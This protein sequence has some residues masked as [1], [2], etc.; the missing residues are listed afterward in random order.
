MQWSERIGRRVKLRDLHVLEAVV[1]AGSM[2]KAADK[3][4]ITVP[5]ISKAI[6]DLEHCV[7]VRLLDRSARGVEVT[8]SGRAL[9]SRSRAAFD[10]LRQGIRDIEQLSDPTAG[11]VRIG[12]TVPL[13]SSFVSAVID[14]FSKR[15]PNV[16][17][18][19]VA[20]QTESADLALRE[21]RADLMIARRFTSLEHDELKFEPLFDDPY[22]I[23]AG[24]HN[25][26]A[27]KRKIELAELAHEAWVVPPP[28]SLVGSV[29]V[30]AFRTKG[31]EFRRPTVVTFNNQARAS[32]VATG[33]FLTILPRSALNLPIKNPLIKELPVE[34][35]TARMP[36][37]A[38]TLRSRTLSASTKLF[39]ECAR[40]VAGLTRRRG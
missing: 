1:E 7:G 9:L 19:V 29:I 27:R 4:G 40:E 23:A 6:A 31:L 33:R 17:F 22:V 15:Y 37:G 13:L 24:L 8:A 16:T 21:R 34:M 32:L 18:V 39:V 38:V 11:E 3:I 35:P 12:S 20:T 5:V 36:I 2:T 26:W 14:R 30:E 10:E 28:D 25:P